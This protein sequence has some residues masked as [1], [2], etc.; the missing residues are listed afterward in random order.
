MLESMRIATYAELIAAGLSPSMIN[1]RCRRGELYRV[2]PT[3]YSAGEPT[4][5][6]R[7]IALARWLPD[8][9]LSH[10]TAAWLHGMLPEPILFEAS[11]PSRVSRRT[12][13][14]L[15]LYRR[16]LR[17]ELIGESWGLPTVVPAR[18]VFDC[19][20][21]LEPDDVGRLVDEQLR[22][23]IEPTELLEL[24]ELDAGLTGTPAARRQLKL[25]ATNFLS[26]PERLFSRRAGRTELPAPRESRCRTVLVR[27]RRRAI[28]DC[29]RNRRP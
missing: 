11:V 15:K 4:A 25:L 28:E 29:H 19:A 6:D 5:L 16:G 12:P 1:R 23:R 24:C 20:S 8:A 14:W 10:R 7:C 18:A 13:K 22:A 2:L 26:E 21:V 3:V 27:L 17:E 9:T